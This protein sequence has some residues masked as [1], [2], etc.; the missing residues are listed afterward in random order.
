[1][2]EACP[3]WTVG[4]SER[5]TPGSCALAMPR[6]IAVGRQ[7]GDQHPDVHGRRDDNTEPDEP[8]DFEDE[9]EAS[10]ATSAD[11]ARQLRR[12]A[13]AHQGAERDGEEHHPGVQGAVTEDALEEQ[14]EDEEDPE[15]ADRHHEDGAQTVR[16]GADGEQRQVDEHHPAAPPPPR[17]AEDEG[18][19][20]HP[21]M[22]QM[23]EMGDGQPTGQCSPP[24]AKCALGVHHP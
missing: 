14:W 11:S 13:T 4:T 6:P 19:E 21:P 16:E 8:D 7:P 24:I 15:L 22:A 1:M 2:P 18:D 23:N 9:P 12:D 10:H 5:I 17:L 3:L 20:A